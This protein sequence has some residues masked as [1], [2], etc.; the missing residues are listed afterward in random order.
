MN[1]HATV[2]FFEFK[3]LKIHDIFKRQKII[4]IFDLINILDELERLFI[5]KSSIHSYETHFSQIF[6][7]LYPFQKLK[8]Q[9]LREFLRF[10]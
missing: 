5:L 2:L 6:H 10:Q 4:F 7:I 9:F 1:Y 3:L 8:I